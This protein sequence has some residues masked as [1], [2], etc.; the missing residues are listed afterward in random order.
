MSCREE[1][2]KYE[3]DVFYEVWCR[4]GNPDRINPDRVENY[5][6]DGI[7]A[8]DAARQELQ[9]MRPKPHIEEEQQFPDEDFPEEPLIEEPQIPEEPTR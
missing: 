2:R 5:F 9:R 8:E 1:R 4:N 3:N 7:S 6:Y